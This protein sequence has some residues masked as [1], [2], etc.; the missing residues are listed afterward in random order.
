MEDTDMRNI[1]IAAFA[2]AM[3]LP[4]MASA[5]P[6]T[7][8]KS[9][10]KPTDIAVMQIQRSDGS[11]TQAKCDLTHHDSIPPG[12]VE[13]NYVEI[14]VKKWAPPGGGKDPCYEYSIGGTLHVVCWP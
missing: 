3:L 10:G 14:W 1:I 2:G 8:K 9:G 4:G 6:P 13:K 12:W 7:C 11:V 5:E